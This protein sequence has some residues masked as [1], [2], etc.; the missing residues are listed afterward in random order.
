MRKKL[1]PWVLALK[2]LHTSMQVL[3]NKSS[4]EQIGLR[5]MIRSSFLGKMLAPQC[6]LC[7]DV[8]VRCVCACVRFAQRR[9]QQ[10]A[11][12]VVMGLVSGEATAMSPVEAFIAPKTIYRHRLDP[13]FAPPRMPPVGHPANRLS[14]SFARRSRGR[15]PKLKVPNS[16]SAHAP[17]SSRI[18]MPKIREQTRN[19]HC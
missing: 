1:N 9:W 15:S 14:N 6:H 4:I 2:H 16:S 7:R 13:A 19:L 10:I 3:E 8:F 12:A 5:K 17:V 18:F 11:C